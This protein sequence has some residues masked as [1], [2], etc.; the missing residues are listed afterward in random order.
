MTRVRWPASLPQYM[1][2]PGARLG[3]AENRL[4]SDVDIG[5]AKVRSLTP[6]NVRPLSGAMRLT[7][8]QWLILRDFVEGTLKGGV[9]AFLFPNPLDFGATRIEVRF[10]DELPSARSTSS[11]GQWIVQL[12]LEEMP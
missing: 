6:L 10:A 1:E 9:R 7:T 11:P 3:V 8:R 12:D 5:P 4:R 2:R